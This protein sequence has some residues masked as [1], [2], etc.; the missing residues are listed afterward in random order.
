MKRD[1]EKIWEVAPPLPME[2]NTQLSMFKPVMRQLLFNRGILTQEQA[3]VYLER[4]GPLYDPF[5]LIGM[6]AA[7]ARIDRAIRLAERIAV[8]GDYDVDG[9]TAT[10]LM[11]QVLR[12]LGGN[13]EA[14]IPDRFDEGYG[15]NNAALDLLAQENVK[16]IVTVDCGIRSLAEAEHAQELGLDMVIS[17]HHEPKTE[18]PEAVAVI[19][20]KQPGDP[21]P[22]KNLAGVGLAFKIAQALFQKIGGDAGQADAWLDLVAVGTVADIVPLNGENRALVKAGLVLLRQGQRQG[23]RSLAGA[24]GFKTNGNLTA[25]DIGFM[26]GPRLNAAGRLESAMAAFDLLMAE[27]YQ[28]AGP[29]ALQLDDQNRERQR[30]TQTMQSEAEELF[31]AEETAPLLIFAYK[32]EFEFK[33]AGLVGL[34]ASRLTDAYYRPSIVACQENG[35]IRASCRSIPEFHITQALDEC[36]DLLV[37][38]G[39]HAMAAGFTVQEDNLSELIAGLNAIAE[40]ELAE[41]ELRP[42]LHADME[43]AL[44]DLRPELLMDLDQLEPTGLGNRS[45][46]FISR[47]LQ[48]KR[49]ILMGSEKQHLKLVV[50][51]GRI[52]YDAVAFRM[53][54]LASD[55]PARI[56]LLYAFERNF[57][58]G[59]V[60]LQLMVRDIKPSA[61]A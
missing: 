21:Y 55:L 43:I 29:L 3:S 13:A 22:E 12:S 45:A 7:V 11:V 31:A 44:R 40:R 59:R 33:S 20:P 46:Y 34:V 58:N 23:L 6:D 24:A 51:D 5:L 27:D 57:Y 53:G 30:L 18:L 10:T 25:R 8:Y 14:Y 35:F 37:R 15:L 38:H 54:H 32:P 49:V 1:L 2:T 47:K 28:V 36:S 48:I 9:V 52:T 50:T 17:D 4:Q 16:L 60:T 19:N 56:D 39:G 41:R 42:V 61:E 26:L